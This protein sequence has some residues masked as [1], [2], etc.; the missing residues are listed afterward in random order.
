VWAV[1]ARQQALVEE[2]QKRLSDRN[3]EMAELCVAYAAVKE[4]AVQAWATE[5]VVREDTKKAREEAAQ[6]RKDLEPLSARV[7]ELEEDVSLV[8]R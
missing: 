4:E 3:A 7:K 1:L 6:A 5:A 8:N 2:A